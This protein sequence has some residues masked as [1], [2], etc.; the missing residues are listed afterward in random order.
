MAG[1]LFVSVNK[2]FDSTFTLTQLAPW[3]AKA[4]ALTPAKAERCDRVIAV[5]KGTPVAAWRLRAA[6]HLDEYTWGDGHP[7][8]GLSLG[9]T[10]PILPVYQ[11]IAPT[12]ALRRGIATVERDDLAPLPQERD[13]SLLEKVGLD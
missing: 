7:R 1:L 4:W 5:Y 11:E 2:T 6:Y 3:V 10:L 8:I 9:D 12:V 13:E